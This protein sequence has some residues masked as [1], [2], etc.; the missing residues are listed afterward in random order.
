MG[1]TMMTKELRELLVEAL[2]P[3]ARAA[4]A[5]GNDPGPIRFYDSTGYREFPPDAFQRAREAYI[6]LISTQS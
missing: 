6:V 3:F 1:G 2:Q 4:T 5:F